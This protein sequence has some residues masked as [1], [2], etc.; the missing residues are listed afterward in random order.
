MMAYDPGPPV[1]AS[2]FSDSN[3]DSGSGSGGSFAE[4]ETNAA[5][6]IVTIFLVALFFAF[7]AGAADLAG[8]GDLP[9]ETSSYSNPELPFWVFILD[10]DAIGFVLAVGPDFVLRTR[11]L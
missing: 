3:V 2:Y 11:S 7:L 4:S 10:P 6:A 1:S 8:H 9:T 5:S